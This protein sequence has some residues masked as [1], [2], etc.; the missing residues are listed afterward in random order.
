MKRRAERQQETRARIVEAAVALHSTVGPAATSISAIA[1]HA[2]VRRQTVYDHF[3]DAASL[4]RACS[5]HW[6]E[7]HPF[8]DPGTWMEIDDPE[9]R[10]RAALTAVYGWYE[11]VAPEF[12]LFSRDAALY[13]EVWE[14]RGRHLRHLADEL[15]T[16]LDADAAPAIAHAFEFTTW[17]SLR[18]HGLDQNGAVDAMARFVEAVA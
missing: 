17:Q 11:D 13:P 16:S 15:A 10:V 6:R 14:E 1:E 7:A 9:R 18:R 8:P 3:P 5:Q 4:F 12:S 2:G